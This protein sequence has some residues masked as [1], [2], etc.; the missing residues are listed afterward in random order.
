MPSARR[1]STVVYLQHNNLKDPTYGPERDLRPG[2]LVIPW[3]STATDVRTNML[4]IH[5]VLRI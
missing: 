2:H 1:D 3:Y 4:M 5:P